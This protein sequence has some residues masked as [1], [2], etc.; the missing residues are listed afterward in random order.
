MV[1][2]AP[3]PAKLNL[4]L[5]VVGRR[6]DG[7]HLLD[8]LVAFAD[9]HDTIEARPA[10]GLSLELA[11]PFGDRL[12]D[13]AD[14]LVLRAARALAEAAGRRPDAAIRLIKRLPVAGG[15]GG[16]SADAAA[17]LRLLSR[18]WDIAL[19]RDK[20]DLL[21]LTLGA[22]VPVCL[23]GRA[24]YIGGVGEKLDAVPRLPRCH[25]VLAN[26][27]L[28][29][30]T[31][32]VFRAREGEFGQ[33]ARFAEAPADAAALAGM[34]ESRTNDLTAAAIACLPRIADGLAALRGTEACLMARMSGSGATCFGLYADAAAARRAA[35][36]LR[37]D[38]PDWWVAPSRLLDDTTKLEAAA[39]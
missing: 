9:L 34:L 15:I 25:L 12:R 27:L 38:L 33:V 8:S 11:G 37:K 19:P 13:E 10:D 20:M 17:V 28:P 30:S 31:P 2:R 3:A 7:Y 29:L 22:D 26:P 16:G 35:S 14:N 39:D 23:A 1:L 32:Q 4:Y 18:F 5:H 6:D 24:A 36:A 21:A